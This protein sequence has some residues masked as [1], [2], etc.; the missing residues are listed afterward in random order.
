MF[1]KRLRHLLWPPPRRP[2]SW[3][4]VVPLALFLVAFAAVC[5][6][7]EWS[8]RLLFARPKMFALLAVTPWVWWMHVAGYSGLSRARGVLALLTRLTLVGLFVMLLAEPRAV[9]TRDVLSVVYAVDLSDSVGDD[10]TRDAFGFMMKTV[11]DKPQKDEAGLVVFGRNAAVELPPRMAFPYE[12][13]INARIDR[14]ATNL[15][16]ALSLAA[17]MVP[18]ENAGRIVL[19]SDGVGTEGSLSQTLDELKSRHIAVDVL[20]IQFDYEQEVWLERLELPRNVKLG[21]SYEAATVLSALTPGKGTLVLRENGETIARQPVEFQ[22]GKNRYVFPIKLRETGYYEYSASIELPTDEDHLRQNNTALNYIFVEGEGKVLVVTNPNRDPRDWQPLVKA[23]REGERLP[24]VRSPSDFPSDVLSLMPYDAVVFVNVPADAFN[25][26]QMQA[27]R[28][29]VYEMGLGFVMVG[30]RNS[31]GP[32]GWHRT[33]IEEALPVSMDVTNKKILP[34]GALAIILHTCEFP[35]GN[36]WGKRITKQAIKVL[37]AKDEVGVLVFGRNREQWLFPLTPASEYESLVTKINAA[38]IGDMPAFGTTMQMGFDALKASDAAAKHMIIISDGDPVPP[39]PSLVRDFVDERISVSMIAI[40]PHGGNDISKMQSIASVTGGRY[41]NPTDPELLPS[42][43]IKESKT[44]KRTMISN[45]TVQL[46]IGFPSAILKGLGDLPPLHGYVLTSAKPRIENIL[47]VQS[48]K[49]QID[50]LLA[51]WRFGLGTTA[52]F[53]SDLSTNWG[54][55]WVNWQEFRAFVKQLMTDV[56]RVRKEG[57]LRL[58]AYTAGN[59]GIIIAEDYAP[60]AAFLEVQARVTGPRDHSE[61]VPLKQ[62]GPR[63][64]QAT[65]PLWGRGRYQVTAIGAAGERHERAADGFIVPYSPEYLRFRSN[66]IVLKEIAQTTGGQLLTAQSTA[67]DLYRG[68]REPK[69]SSKPVFDWFLIALACLV[70]LDVGLRRVQLDW[71]VIRGWFASQKQQGPSTATM[72]TLLER[73]KEVAAT[74][75]AKRSETP[76]P[77]QRVETPPVTVTTSPKDAPK[78]TT[79]DESETVT[80]R[81]LAA[82]RRRQEGEGNE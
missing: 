15:E 80:S 25:A 44:L 49:D 52:A 67:D 46:R 18:A 54:A 69:R 19:I 65:V 82:K 76:L 32:G 51:K 1:R 34:K 77:P 20:P 3:R 74:L 42:I 37:G 21:E 29:A 71:S 64:Y 61:T 22:A 36:T 72:G 33:P 40:F 9:R 7:L 58:W 14:D 16:Q 24:E 55:D 62:V 47:D 13:A 6:W 68:R 28:D 5:L 35:E 27:L 30:G 12:G 2:L 73:K 56:A 70:P 81:L 75:E 60:E 38:E 39:V 78:P 26:I 53:T 11:A 41:Y 50:P 79:T 45:E 59:E 17:A 10:M 31:F 48:E 8:H 66:P 4:S 63:R 23:L 43:F 57:Q